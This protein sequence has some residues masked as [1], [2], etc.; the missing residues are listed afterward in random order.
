VLAKE[1][2]GLVGEI[3]SFLPSV[4][5]VG[6]RGGRRGA[7]NGSVAVIRLTIPAKAEY[8]SLCRLAL[9]GLSQATP[10]SD[11]LL[12]DLK[13][14]LTEAASNS[15]RHAYKG[16]EGSV[17]ITYE[18]GHDRL[19]IEVVDDGQGFVHEPEPGVEDF[20]GDSVSEGGLGIAIIRTIADEFDVGPGPN[21]RGSRL[22][23][24]KLLSG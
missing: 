16:G 4:M 9:T 2:R 20:E 3:F 6:E 5:P 13:L 21:G 10:L 24:V 22:R 8:V 17:E 19:G 18:L 1:G 15:V 14:A 12:A 7:G 11:E 23:F